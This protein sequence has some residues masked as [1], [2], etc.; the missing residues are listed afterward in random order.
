MTCAAGGT[1][2]RRGLLLALALLLAVGAPGCDDGRGAAGAAGASAT[3]KPAVPAP[4]GLLA[5]L[6]VPAPHHLVAELRRAAGGPVLFLPRTVG[7]LVTNLFGFPLRVVELVDERLPI[8]GVVAAAPPADGGAGGDE[9]AVAIHVKSGQRFTAQASAG[10]DGS[11]SAK[12]DGEITWLIPKPEARAARLDAAVAVLDS[13][14]VIG[15]GQGAVRR[16]GPYLTR[17]L[18]RR[19]PPAGGVHVELTSAAFGDPLRARLGRW[20]RRLAALPLPDQLRALVDLDALA[21]AAGT[22]LAELGKGSV[23][24]SLDDR[25]L[26]VSATA[27]PR[28]DAAAKRLAALP[29]VAPSQLLVLPDDTVAAA[30][31]AETVAG[32]LARAKRSGPAM[33]ALFG[34]PFSAADQ[35]ELARTFETLAK[36]QGDQLVVGL[37]CTGVGI[38]GFATG[39]VQDEKE[40]S[41]GLEALV[42]LRKHPAVVA[43]L[44]ARSLS[45]Q[46][47]KSRVLRVPHDVWKIG[48]KPS[49]KSKTDPTATAPGEPAKSRPIGLVL[50]WSAEHLW[51]AAGLQ[52]V[53]TVQHLYEPDAERS[54]ASR[55]TLKSAIDRL[56]GKAW[57][58]LLLDPQGMH[59]CWEGK[60][61]GALA[62]PV[63]LAAGLG[64]DQQVRLRLELARPLL[65]VAV[66]QLGGF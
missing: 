38:T 49:A 60:P 16:L 59:A 37:R 30:G 44:E 55:E 21:Q 48:L 15:S 62:T 19:K 40:L 61:G 36:G 39:A 32:R 42:K 28:D 29:T 22:F 64:A 2:R 45:V 43:Q 4:A 25:A 17:T 27:Q 57:V 58:V 14:L 53:E 13:Y 20:H 24:L 63:A 54:L 23:T 9:L 11:F 26:V 6:V 8:V 10:A 52:A 5:E 56:G 35:S 18:A 31:W 51:A 47:K 12:P 46:A 1:A 41:T 34:E 7:G 65:R 66:K 50:G 3:Q 33:A